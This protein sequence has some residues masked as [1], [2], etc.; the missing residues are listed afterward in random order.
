VIV[1]IHTAYLQHRASCGL[2]LAAKLFVLHVVVQY[3][4]ERLRFGLGLGR[5][6]IANV[7]SRVELI[8][9][10]CMMMMMMMDYNFCVVSFVVVQS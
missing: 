2:A 5:N 1:F 6:C 9:S 3:Q 4:D 7:V 10:P 8:A